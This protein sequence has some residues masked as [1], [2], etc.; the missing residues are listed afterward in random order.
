MKPSDMVNM[1]CKQPTTS[2]THRIG[3]CYLFHWR[4]ALGRASETASASFGARPQLKRK[5]KCQGSDTGRSAAT[6]R[7]HA[8]NRSTVSVPGSGFFL[9]ALADTRPPSRSRQTREGRCRDR[10]LDRAGRPSLAGVTGRRSRAGPALASRVVTGRRR[11]AGPATAS[12]PSTA[13]VAAT[14]IATTAIATV[15]TADALLANV[16]AKVVDL[17]SNSLLWHPAL[18]AP[19]ELVHAQDTIRHGNAGHRLMA[20]GI[21]P[22]VT[23]WVGVA[24]LKI[25]CSAN[26]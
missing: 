15:Q 19:Q 12:R 16:V 4:V 22:E 11:P 21:L 24:K 6:P 13:T 7:S 9:D 26:R 25:K 23:R 5:K 20:E 8:G 2:F 10:E 14:R 1:L 17:E 18:F 3:Y